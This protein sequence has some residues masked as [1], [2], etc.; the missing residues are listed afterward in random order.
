MAFDI[1]GLQSYVDL[2]SLEIAT[3]AVAGAETAKLLIENNSVQFG[4]KAPQAILRLDAD[5]NVQSNTSCSRT[6]VGTTTL[7]NKLISV[8]QMKD[9]QNICPKVL[10]NTFYS[11]FLN[12]GQNPEGGV[13]A[14][15]AEKI[16]SYRATKLANWNENHLWSG[17][18]GTTASSYSFY[19]GIVKQIQVGSP[20]GLTYSGSD[21]VAKLQKIYIATPVEVR[22]Q[23][24]FR[25]FIGKDLYAQY[26]IDLSIRNIYKPTQDNALFGTPALLQPVSG[27]NGTNGVVSSRISNF[28]LGLDAE[29]DNDKC[30]MR[31]SMETENF[32]LDFYWAMGITVVYPEKAGYIVIA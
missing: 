32:Y 21:V 12:A 18:S 17:V 24:D 29:G 22:E 30:V 8:S 3:K 5:V 10:Q 25:I 4:V 6:A 23:E 1:S 11:V 7:S 9:A 19:D 14:Q 28:H 15:L 16:T 27:L 20:F 13:T 2:N 31:Y 26:L